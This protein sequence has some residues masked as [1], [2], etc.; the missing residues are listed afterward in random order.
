LTWIVAA[1]FA[2]LNPPRGTAAPEVE[3]RDFNVLVDGKPGGDVHMTINKQEDGSVIMTCDT[4]I[5]VQVAI[6]PFTKTYTYSYRG[7]EV[8]K[9]GRIV[10]FDSNCNDDGKRM[11]V[12]AVAEGDKLRVKVNNE[13]K[14]VGGDVWLTSYWEMPENTRINQTVSIIDAD[15]GADLSSKVTFLGVEQRAVAG[16]AQKVNHFRLLG[17]TTCDLWYDLSGRLVAQDWMEDGHRTQVDLNR[18]RR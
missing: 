2:L 16:H 13:E 7:R 1:F 4:D 17:K 15:S 9:A 6:G 3:T 14:V 5:K 8:W 12:A 18:L 10:R 11:A